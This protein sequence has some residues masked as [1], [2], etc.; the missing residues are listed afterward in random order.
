MDT[1]ENV[2]LSACE[3]F[4]LHGYHSA[5]TAEICSKAGANIAAINY[6]YR[7]KKNI[8][9]AVWEKLSLDDKA[10]RASEIPARGSV[11]ERLFALLRYNVM[12]VLT[13]GSANWFTKIVHRELSSP[14]PMHGE[15]FNHYLEPMQNQFLAVIRDF[16]GEQADENNVRLCSLCVHGPIYDLLSF[17]IKWDESQAAKGTQY[18][19]F[20]ARSVFIE[21]PEA[22]IQHIQHYTLGGLD[23]VRNNQCIAKS[24]RL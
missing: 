24:H 15:L 19:L 12:A 21:D 9:M 5:T 14:S 6:Y 1:Q 7:G 18:P 4:S 10:Q 3:V 13:T 23:A 20:G 22:L 11:R 16:L 2:L 17:R 8:Y